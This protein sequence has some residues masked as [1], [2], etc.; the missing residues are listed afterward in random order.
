MA[1]AS[2]CMVERSASY[3]FQCS[4]MVGLE[5]K[6]STCKIHPWRDKIWNW[7]WCSPTLW[8]K[9]VSQDHSRTSS[10]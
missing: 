2:Q 7:L 1:V 3:I 8:L 6:R 5:E 4:R 10:V 9:E